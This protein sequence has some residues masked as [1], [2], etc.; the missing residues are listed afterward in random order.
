[1]L[2]FRSEQ[3][4]AT[5]RTEQRNPE[6][7]GIAALPTLD[8]L[9]MINDLDQTVALAV[10][11]AL[12]Q[13]AR[14]VEL[15]VDGLARGGRLVYVGA[16]T[17][18]RLGFMDAA[19]CGPT[20]GVDSVRCVMAGGRDAVFQ[21]Q[22]R[23]EDEERLAA[24]DLR[25]FGLTAAD[26]VVAAA[27]SGR[28]PYCIAALDYAARIGA[29]RVSISCNPGAV[30][31]E[32]A[33]IG[34]EVDTGP[35]AIMG[36]TRMKAGTAQKLVM[37]MISTAAM[38]RLGRTYDNLMI[39][40]DCKNQKGRNR[41][42]RLLM[43]AVGWEDPDHAKAAL[44]RADG[45]VEVAALMALAGVTAARAREALAAC[46]EHFQDALA[47]LAAGQSSEKNLSTEM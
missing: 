27:A 42:E 39:K 35:E 32:H 45:S 12:P 29:G 23:L 16:G 40:L 43:E 10:R 46:G 7:R 22:E 30:L 11:Q 2:D 3:A 8:M 28:T 20:Y 31:S 21:A 47:W 1:M 25:A 18:G 33:Q 38:I 6:T 44:D 4:I 19:E 13:I 36:S 37:N 26:V 14:A 9:R 24:K 34:I 17:S 41:A 5:L 15:V